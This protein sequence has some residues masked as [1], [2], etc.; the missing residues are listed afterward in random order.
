MAAFMAVNPILEMAIDDDWL[1]ARMAQLFAATGHLRYNGWTAPMV[2]VHALWGALFIRIFGFS[3]TVLRFSTAVTASGCAL[4]CHGIC[5][6]LGLSPAM[7]AFTAMTAM[8]SPLAIAMTATFM[9]DITGMFLFLVLLYAALGCAQADTDAACMGWLLAIVCAG[10]L[11]C[12]VR[13]VLIL[14][15]VSVV[16]SVMALRWRSRRIILAGLCALLCVCACAEAMLK[17]LYSQPGAIQ[18]LMSAPVLSRPQLV[19]T[20][21]TVAG[22]V[23]TMVALALPILGSALAL[24]AVWRKAGTIALPA[25]AIVLAAACFI[26][27]VAMPPWLGNVIT[28][29][30]GLPPKLAILGDKPVVLPAGA[31]LLFAA[32]MYL[33]ASVFA[34]VAFYALRDRIRAFHWRKPMFSNGPGLTLVVIVLPAAGL[35][36]AALIS[37]NL[38]GLEVYDRYLLPVMGGIL[39]ALALFHHSWISPRI[40]RI[41]WTLLAFCAALGIAMMHDQTAVSRATLAAANQ[42][43]RAGLPRTCFSAGYEYDGWTQLLAEGYIARSNLVLWEKVHPRFWFELLVP[44]IKPCYYVVLSPQAGLMPSEFEPVRYRTWLSPRQREVLTQR[45][46]LCDGR[47]CAR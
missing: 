35:Y 32:V 20:A 12:S 9:T 29:F 21:H 47:S 46:P 10:V 3:F 34:G 4:V 17:W 7:S 6:R 33:A 37:H 39:P 23:L 27:A 13:Q 41:G 45:N 11:A 43:T 24:P 19:R 26:P 44:A 15:A 30:G 18:G 22:T 38:S 28:E 8:L 16:V 25:T 31:R 40:T 36:C 5:R 14:P 1:F 42:L 2:G